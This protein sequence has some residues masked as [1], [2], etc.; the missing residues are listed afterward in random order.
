MRVLTD[1]FLFSVV[2]GNSILPNSKKDGIAFITII[3]KGIVGHIRNG[4][5]RRINLVG[6][7]YFV[8]QVVVLFTGFVV[9]SVGQV[10]I[11]N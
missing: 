5:G 3:I 4:V 7:I 10:P 9:G 2:V 1:N 11:S 8:G 6:R